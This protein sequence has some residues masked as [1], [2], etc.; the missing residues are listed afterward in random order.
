MPM[1]Y[2]RASE[3]REKPS[4]NQH[5]RIITG[6]VAFAVVAGALQLAAVET[7]CDIKSFF[8]NRQTGPKRF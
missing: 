4:K 6:I 8:L 2:N 3:K 7:Y 1:T 5:G